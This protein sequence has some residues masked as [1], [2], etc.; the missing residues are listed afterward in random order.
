MADI[1]NMTFRA[2]FEIEGVTND[3]ERKLAGEYLLAVY[4]RTA[5]FMNDGGIDMFHKMWDSLHPDT[6]SKCHNNDEYVN[7]YDRFFKSVADDIVNKTLPDI[8][9]AYRLRTYEPVIIDPANGRIIV[10]G[11]KEN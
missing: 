7:A 4:N 11:Y 2:E 8:K 6:D 3:L 10:Y 5:D 1:T 9:K